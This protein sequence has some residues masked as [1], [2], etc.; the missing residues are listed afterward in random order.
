MR[1]FIVRNN[2]NG[3][4]IVKAILKAKE[5]Y[6]KY[7]M[8]AQE[9]LRDNEDKLNIQIVEQKELNSYLYGLYG[10][11]EIESGQWRPGHWFL[12]FPGTD[13]YLRKRLMEDYENQYRYINI[14]K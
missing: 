5:T 7:S 3:K 12:H 13:F 4:G 11:P 9:F 2:Q 8:Q 6:S 1:N 10:L 14:Q